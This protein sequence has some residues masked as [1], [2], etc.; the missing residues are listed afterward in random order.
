MKTSILNQDAECV[1]LKMYKEEDM[2]PLDQPDASHAFNAMIV[3][4][5]VEQELTNYQKMKESH[6]FLTLF[7]ERKIMRVS[8]SGTQC[9]GKS[10]V[11]ED[12]LKKWEMYGTSEKTYRNVI[13]ERGL[14]INRETT[15]EVQSIIMDHLCD[16]ILGKTKDDYVIH[17]RNPIDCLAY[18][19]Y[20]NCKGV[21]GFDDDFIINQIQIAREAIKHYDIIFFIALNQY[22]MVPLV[23]DSLR[24]SD[25]K[26][27]EEVDIIFK[28]IYG[29]YLNQNGP[30]FDFSDCPA[31]IEIFGT[32]EERIKMIEFYINENGDMFGDEDSLISDELIDLRGNP[33]EESTLS[34]D[35]IEIII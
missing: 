19:I 22:N 25:K 26:Y 27:R 13:Q 4:S 7:K 21:E 14:S 28:E 33:L 30:Y 34:D 8:I 31:I 16:Q 23:D 3:A 1:V 35:D 29:T 10:T 2:L 15:P 32:P 20:M 18:S 17:D 9:M 6:C 24:D 5:G 11:V 12:F